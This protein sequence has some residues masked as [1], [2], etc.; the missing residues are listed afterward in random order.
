ME[1]KGVGVGYD[2]RH[3]E[4]WNLVF[5]QLYQHPDGRR[6]PLPAQ[7]IDT[8]SGLERVAMVIQAWIRSSRPTSSIR[9]SPR[10]LPSST[11]TTNRRT[12][13]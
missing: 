6:E 7:N 3:L 1:A 8:G 10:R 4:I 13:T 5:M 12:K 2:E 9:S 11:C